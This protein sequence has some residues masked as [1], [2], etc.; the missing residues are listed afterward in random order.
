MPMPTSSKVVSV[1][2]WTLLLG[3]AALL[4]KLGVLPALTTS[5]GDFANYYTAA[6]LVA[7]GNSLER[8]YRDFV[9]F[10]QQMDRV[11]IQNQVG[12]FIPHPPPTALVLLPLQGLEALTAKRV[13]IWFNVALLVLNIFLLASISG[14]RWLLAGVLFLASGYGLV[15]NFLFG[16]QYLL[17]TTSLLLCLFL[18]Q[19]GLP[20]AAGAALGVMIP[21]KYVGVLF[22][23]YFAWKR[24]WKLA[25]SAVAVSCAMILLTLWLTDMQT[26]ETF[27]QEVL[28]RHLKGEI[29]EPFSVLFQSWNSL[30]RRLFVYEQTLNPFPVVEAPLL[31]ALSKSAVFAAIAGTGLFVLTRINLRRQHQFLFEL[32]WLPL[33]LLLLS[34]GS[35]T[36]HFLLLGITVVFLVKILL[37]QKRLVAALALGSLFIIVNL[38][39]FMKTRGLAAGWMN[40]LAYPRLMTLL[41]FFLATL[42]LFRSSIN[43]RTSRRLR[44]VTAAVFLLFVGIPTLRA[45]AANPT[46]DGARWRRVGSADFDK[47]LGLILKSPSLGHKELVFA[48]CELLADDYAIYDQHGR[49]LLR[50]QQR[51]FYNPALAPDDAT[52]LV[53]TVS[54]GRTEIWLLASG[55][56]LPRF[57]L[58]GNDPA[59]HPDADR[60][61]CI[62]NNRI[63]VADLDGIVQWQLNTAGASAPAF[64]ADGESLVYCV[65]QKGVWQLVEH[66]LK[67][68][69]STNLLTSSDRI[70]A[71]AWANGDKQIVF[72]WEAAGN[73]DI[74]SLSRATNETRQLTSSKAAD[75]GPVWDAL[76]QRIIFTSDRGRGLEFSTLYS[77]DRPEGW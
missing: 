74:W 62:S 33:V 3:C 56:E 28:P 55:A 37:D 24:E 64:S 14:I 53:E 65:E 44:Y 36:Y 63:V 49:V 35:A 30:L 27:V 51:N 10:Q 47:H 6:R 40:L 16:Q 54:G 1:L 4:L 12:G 50:D 32:A 26:F 25:L 75:E 57:V 69:R 13:W 60:F 21:V 11:G 18:Y 15:N 5:K 31:F 7:E 43:W 45:A 68:A 70:K 2:L 29:Q 77:L 58:A 17:V 8:A 71:P 46:V 67:N 22:V 61:A 38:P 48:Y 20:L 39:I 9:W 59:W 41:A 73:R 66:T 23:L 72:C 52:L 34:P 42:F 19:K 76:Q